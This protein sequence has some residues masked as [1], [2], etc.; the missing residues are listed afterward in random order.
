MISVQE[1]EEQA[2]ETE[3]DLESK[4][5]PILEKVHS[6]ILISELF[7]SINPWKT[8][9]LIASLITL[10]VRLFVCLLF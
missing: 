6:S 10:F 2:K 1:A 7:S 5:L 3:D 8:I 9:R 4:T